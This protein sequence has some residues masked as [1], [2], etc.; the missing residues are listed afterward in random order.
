MNLSEKEFPIL[1][2][3]GQEEISTQRE[4]A[5]RAG[6]SLG[7]VN[8]VLKNFLERGLVKI[9]NFTKSPKK[10]K[11]VYRLTSKGIEAKSALAAKFFMQKLREYGDVKDKLAQRLSPLEAQKHYR[12]FF[13]GPP[14]VGGLIDAVIQEKHLSLMLVGQCRVVEDL[15]DYDADFFDA[16][17]L[18][19]GNGKRLRASAQAVDVPVEKFIFFW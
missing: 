15:T 9:T 13:V 16:V 17:L 5:D 18:F 2:A 6:I 10:I 4:L 14:L 11:Y 19:E 3:L 1:D 7:Q 12:L 8:Y